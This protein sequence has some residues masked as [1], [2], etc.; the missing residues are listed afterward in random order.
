MGN[1]YEPVNNEQWQSLMETSTSGPSTCLQL[2]I[3]VRPSASGVSVP[4]LGRWQRMEIR[5]RDR[6]SWDKSLASIVSGDDAGSDRSARIF[7]HYLIPDA[8]WADQV[9]RYQDGFRRIF[10]LSGTKL[11][12]EPEIVR[13]GL[14]TFDS[15]AVTT[16]Y[17]ALTMRFPFGNAGALK[18]SWTVGEVLDL[19]H[20]LVGS[21]MLGEVS[22]D[23]DAPLGTVQPMDAWTVSTGGSTVDGE[24]MSWHHMIGGLLASSGALRGPFELDRGARPVSMTSLVVESGIDRRSAIRITEHLG[25]SMLS[26]TL[27]NHPLGVHDGSVLPDSLFE[28][29]DRLCY[30]VTQRAAGLVIYPEDNGNSYNDY[31]RSTLPKEFQTQDPLLYL[32][33]L[34]QQRAL[35]KIIEALS[36]VELM[37]TTGAT[38]SDSLSDDV[39]AARRELADFKRIQQ[40]F[41]QLQA[42][43]RYRLVSPRFGHQGFYDLV[44]RQY[45]VEDSYGDV[46]NIIDGLEGFLR[47]S[48]SELEQR[49]SERRNED[50]RRFER[51][52]QTGGLL[53]AL[54][55]VALS[56]LSINIRGVTAD[57]EG[58]SWWFPAGIVVLIV[59]LAVIGM[60]AVGRRRLVGQPGSSGEVGK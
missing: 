33:A 26:T 27:P 19:N 31:L 45:R 58:V 6:R 1:M 57:G 2:F 7:L 37:Q 52:V 41:H 12:P 34:H 42:W 14:F 25:A 49:A 30:V 40:S 18:A 29:S 53:F 13:V 47:T 15:G 43:T 44:C 35:G 16:H 5:T 50:Q 17:L 28:R 48:F 59:G 3:P 10:T 56:V 55:A 39:A 54:L 21:E 46:D 20:Q 60:V 36:E 32:L 24:C 38:V 8:R 22:Q 11:D 51:R 9:L 23:V 4:P